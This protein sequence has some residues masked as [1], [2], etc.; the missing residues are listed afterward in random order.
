MHDPC[1]LETCNVDRACRHICKQDPSVPYNTGLCQ[2][3]YPGEDNHVAT[4]LYP[5]K[6]DRLL[7]R[8]EHASECPNV[9]ENQAVEK[10]QRSPSRAGIRGGEGATSCDHPQRSEER[11][12]AFNLSPP[13]PSPRCIHYFCCST[14]PHTPPASFRDTG[15]TYHNGSRERMKFV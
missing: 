6:P 2:D 11:S 13:P 4:A 9:R 3:R 1:I 8:A 10:V 12:V 7:H 15:L 5:R 14:M